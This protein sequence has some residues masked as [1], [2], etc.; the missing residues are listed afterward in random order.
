MTIEFKYRTDHKS[1]KT[2]SPI[3][4]RFKLSLFIDRNVQNDSITSYKFAYLLNQFAH[5][6]YGCVRT[7]FV[8]PFRSVANNKIIE[9][10]NNYN[11]T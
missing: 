1:E 11:L 9:Y 6:R 7:N 10:T 5:F 8:A 2:G 3:L 4:D